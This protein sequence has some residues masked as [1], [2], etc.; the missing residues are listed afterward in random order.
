MKR[1]GHDLV[2]DTALSVTLHLIF[3]EVHLCY[4]K[5]TL[6]LKE[7]ENLVI[8]AFTFFSRYD[9]SQNSPYHGL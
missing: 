9:D 6:Y 8:P 7:A 1:T 2:G 4:Q 5:S 3:I